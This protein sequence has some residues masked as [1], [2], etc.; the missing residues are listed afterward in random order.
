MIGNIFNYF[1]LIFSPYVIETNSPPIKF[2]LREFPEPTAF[3]RGAAPLAGSEA[4]TANIVI[5][6]F[7]LVDAFYYHKDEND[8]NVL[9]IRAIWTDVELYFSYLNIQL[10]T[11]SDECYISE[12]DLRSLKN[13]VNLVMNGYSCGRGYISRFITSLFNPK[14]KRTLQSYKELLV[15]IKQLEPPKTRI[16]KIRDFFNEYFQPNVALSTLQDL[17]FTGR[18]L[19]T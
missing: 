2:V 12:L 15:K 19:D 4:L 5:S 7:S 17:A 10:F 1:N 14:Y 8:D 3:P 18:T 13:R 16:Q 9:V 11:K 6:T